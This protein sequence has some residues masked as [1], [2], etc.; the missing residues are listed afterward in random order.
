MAGEAFG[1][2]VRARLQERRRAAAGERGEGEFTLRLRF[3]VLPPSDSPTGMA[4]RLGHQAAYL[5]RSY[6]AF[7]VL[8][9]YE[10]ARLTVVVRFSYQNELEA[11]RQRDH[12]LWLLELAARSAAGASFS[13]AL[14]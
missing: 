9:V 2:P 1:G 3:D 10:P 14:A 8:L 7:K 11:S 6:P 4:W 5:L 13:S 12:V